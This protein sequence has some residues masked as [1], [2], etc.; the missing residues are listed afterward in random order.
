MIK[1][2]IVLL[3]TATPSMAAIT[4]CDEFADYGYGVM[5]MKHE[6]LSKN[7]IIRESGNNPITIII[8]HM[9]SLFDSDIK[10]LKNTDKIPPIKAIIILALL[11]A[12][13]INPCNCE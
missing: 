6:G 13:F 4:N 2:L 11:S 10:K 9:E 3:M 8:C 7:R 1:A 12:C 5:Q